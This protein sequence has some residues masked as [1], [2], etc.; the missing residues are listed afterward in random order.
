M[1]GINGLLRLSPAAPPLDRE[2]LLRTRERMAARGPDGAGDWVSPEGRTALASRRLAILDLSAAGDQPMA[3]ADGRLRAVLNGEIYNFRELRAALERE[4][5]RFRSHS[6]TEVLLA[7][8]AREGAAML[9]RLRGMFGLALWDEAEQTLLLARDPLGVKPLYY[10]VEGGVLRFASQVKAL[11]AGGAVSRAV[12]PAGLAGF[13]L[14]GSVPEPWTIRRGVRAL[15]AG[16]RLLVR[17]GRIEAPAPFAVEPAAEPEA[18]GAGDAAAALADSVRAHLVSDVPVAVFLSAGLDSTLVAALA[19]R[20]APEPPTTFTLRFDVLAGTERDEGPLAAEVARRLG[21]SH[22]ERTVR[23]EDFLDL[24]PA[25]LDA[26]DQPAIDGF[27]V[28]LVSKAAHE[29]GIKVALSGLGGDE[30]FGGYPS[31]ADVPRLQRQARRARRV[32]GLPS[33]WPAVARRVFAERPKLAG[34][35][36][37]GGTLPGAYFLRRGLFLPEELPALL[38]TDAAAEGLAAY[39]PIADAARSLATH[40]GHLPGSAEAWLAVQRLETRH[41]LRNQLLRDADWAAMAHSLELRVPLVDAWLLARFAALDF[42]PARS[43]GKRELVRGAAPELPEAVFHRAKTGFYVPVVPWLAAGGER[44]AAPQGLGAQS[45]QV[46]LRVLA[47]QGV[48]LAAGAG[49][50]A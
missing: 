46:A 32:P 21:T 35:L 18:D 48:E 14:W 45:R 7:L 13:L 12:E 4:G 24:W 49:R 5:R 25:A 6:D 19:S 31:F 3:S 2:E 30:L 16:H 20:A 26:M 37:H 8:Y 10:A 23:R 42:E 29:A 27:N 40:N 36:R 1:C 43:S 38:G 9:R 15:P 33:L 11:E 50:A 39:D 22:V 34:A 28:F 47:E 41:Y 17:D 44:P